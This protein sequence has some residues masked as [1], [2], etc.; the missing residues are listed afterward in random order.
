M[1]DDGNQ[2]SLLGKAHSMR[3]LSVDSDEPFSS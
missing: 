2:L 3:H 1:L